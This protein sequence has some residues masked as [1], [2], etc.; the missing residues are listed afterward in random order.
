MNQIGGMYY[1]GKGV[2]QDYAE[3]LKWYRKAAEKGLATAMSNIAYMYYK[4]K[5]VEK[6]LDAAYDWAIKAG[7]N[8]YDLTVEEPH[9]MTGKR[10][11]NFTL[12]TL[13]GKQVTLN[14]LDADVVILAFW[15][16]WCP[17]SHEAIPLVDRELRSAWSNNR[18]VAFYGINAGDTTQ[19][20][21]GFVREHDIGMPMLM[22]G[23]KAVYE[24]YETPSFPTAMVIANGRVEYVF[25]GSHVLLAPRLRHA[26]TQLLEKPRQ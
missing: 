24:K 21:Q 12:P 5:G 20:A 17:F 1:S 15:A 8:G 22:D 25:V 3:A 18:K 19:A 6:D 7:D 14:E 23:D 13:D 26:I 4:G 2:G 16:A 9:P 10:A 11:A